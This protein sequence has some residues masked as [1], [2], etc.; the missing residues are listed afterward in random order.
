MTRVLLTGAGGFVGHH[1]LEHFLET[2][3][4]QVVCVD[5]FRHRGKTDRINEVLD[6]RPYHKPRVKVVTHD[7]R[8]P[9]SSKVDRELGRIDYLVSV[10]SESHVERSILEPRDFIENNVQLI[11]T[12]LDYARQAGVE[13][14]LHISTDEVYGPAPEGHDHVEGEPHRPSN[15]YSASKAAQEAI[16]YSYWRT[17]GLPC[18]ISNT[19]NIVGERQDPEKYVP[20]IL[21]AIQRGERVTVHASP[22]G[23]PG[24]RYY[25]HA[26]NQADALRFLLETQPFPRYGEFVSPGVRADMGRWNVV[27]EREVDNLELAH[28]VADAA[29]CALRYELMDFHASRPGH[30]RR[31]ALDGTK[32]RELGW[33]P[34]VPFEPSL[35]KTV[36]WTLE[37]PE[38]LLL[39]DEDAPVPAEAA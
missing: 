32:M 20:R 24:S 5:S 26:R 12:L 37:H 36:A 19:M 33:A 11:L 23:Q 22:D 1:V 7:L 27:G 8:A 15:P 29:G 39:D 14:F 6:G 13:K 25:L 38:W 4:W 21:R 35:R 3:D 18:G 10:A 31:Y 28:L 2:T 17:Y 9:F 34:P 30:D 16:V